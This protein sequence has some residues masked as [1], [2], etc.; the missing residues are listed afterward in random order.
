MS[1]NVPAQ[2]QRQGQVGEQR[3][4]RRGRCQRYAPGKPFPS[5]QG[6]R[7]EDE[8]QQSPGDGRHERHHRPGQ[9]VIDLFRAEPRR[10][11]KV[12]QGH[13]FLVFPDL[14]DQPPGLLPVL[15]P[16]GLGDDVHHL[17][18]EHPALV[19]LHHLGRQRLVRVVPPDDAGGIRD[20]IDY[21]GVAGC[22]G[23][24]DILLLRLLDRS[25]VLRLQLEGDVLPPVIVEQPA[26]YDLGGA[27]IA[28]MA[29]SVGFQG[30]FA[31]ERLKGAYAVVVIDVQL[32]ETVRDLFGKDLGEVLRS[33]FRSCQQ[34][35]EDRKGGGF[36][37]LLQR[38]TENRPLLEEKADERQQQEDISG[39][40]KAD[41]PGVVVDG[42]GGGSFVETRLEQP[43]A[44]DPGDVVHGNLHRPFGRADTAAEVLGRFR[45]RVVQY[46]E[47]LEHKRLGQ[48]T[49]RPV[50]PHPGPD[51]LAFGKP[52]AS[53]FSRQVG[54]EG[55][56]QDHDE[57]DVHEQGPEA[58]PRPGNDQ[59]E[60]RQGHR[61][62][63]DEEHGVVVDQ[64]EGDGRT[65]QFF[66]NGGSHHRQDDGC[67]RTETQ[68][69]Q[70]TVFFLHQMESMNLT[71]ASRSSL[72]RR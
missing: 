41:A 56:C 37:D 15:L 22:D 49:L 65:L 31:G 71:T 53:L 6:N 52:H 10:G 61:G 38:L 3:P 39:I 58:L 32:P 57:G 30:I 67:Q 2:S 50:I 25:A 60:A 48:G 26:G 55:P 45:A 19:V 1:G 12:G 29:F 20:G 4:G 44:A 27:V 8:Q 66:N 42:E 68:W 9:P 70:D 7:Q 23:P 11:R 43:I 46:V 17:A 62:P 28:P 13:L 47:I 64:A 5:G 24:Q 54:D 63:Q 40:G 18:D 59:A 21:P 34:Q 35:Q 36:Q 16:H 14:S 33:G 51:G 69:N 72:L